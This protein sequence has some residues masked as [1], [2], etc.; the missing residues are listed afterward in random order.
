MKK[1]TE[2]Y[3]KNLKKKKVLKNIIDKFL[4]VIRENYVV[5]LMLKNILWKNTHFL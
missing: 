2:N 1:A 5:F 4:C 3:P